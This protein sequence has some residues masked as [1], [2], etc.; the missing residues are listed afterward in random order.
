[1]KPNIYS[2]SYAVYIVCDH[3]NGTLYIGV[4][5]DLKRRVYEHKNG[6]IEGFTEKYGLDKLVYYEIYEDV[7]AAILRE[8][9]MKKWKRAWK[10]G[11]ILKDNRE[12]R[13]LYDEI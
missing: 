10:V 2:K 5:N 8:K 4:T 13:D 12:W 3:P 7:E 11:L 1:M 9:R 6:L